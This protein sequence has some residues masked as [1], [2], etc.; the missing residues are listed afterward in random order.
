MQNT[1]HTTKAPE[2][3]EYTVEGERERKK[4]DQD[5]EQRLSLSDIRDTV[6]LT[7]STSKK[8][9]IILRKNKKERSF[10]K[11]NLLTS[12]PRLSPERWN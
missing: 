7:F 9:V 10:G 2:T 6:F 5:S 8:R 11:D 3:L 4:T 1:L 12:P